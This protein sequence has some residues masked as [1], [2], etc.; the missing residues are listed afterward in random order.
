MRRFWIVLD[1]GKLSEYVNWKDKLDLH[2]DPID[3]RMAS[4]RESR[5]SERRFCFEVITPTYTRVYQAPSEEDMKA[6]I[7][8]INNA[9]QSA[10]ETRDVAT[11]YSAETSSSTSGPK[12]DIAAVLTGKSSSFSG[13][14]LTSYSSSHSASQKAVARHATTGDKPTYL[15]P[16]AADSGTSE[17]LQ[18]VR[19][20]DQGNRFCAD[21]NSESKVEWVSI[22]LGIVLCIECSGIHRSLGT[23]I[24]KVR[25]LTLDNSAFT[26]DIIDVLLLVGNRIS[27]M[28][29]EARLDRNTK[30]SPNSN[31]EQRL[32]FIQA[33]YDQRAFVAPTAQHAD[34]LLL[35]SIKRNDIQ[36]VLHALALRANPNVLDRSR[37]T[38]AVFLALAAADPAMPGGNPVSATFPNTRSSTTLGL[39]PHTLATIPQSPA[40]PMRISGELSRPGTPSSPDRRRFPVAE[41][42][43]QNGADLPPLPAPIP[44]TAAAMQY[45][46]FK[47]EQRTGARTYAASPSNVNTNLNTGMS[48][49]AG[50]RVSFGG[51]VNV[52]T[53]DASGDGYK[54]QPQSATTAKSSWAS[55]SG[56]VGGVKALGGGHDGLKR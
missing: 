33:K 10:F 32:Q 13:H 7:N 4:V 36:G 24:S 8:A 40:T 12:K 38:H 25:S 45:L 31:R 15:R 30:L 2:M 39:T 47:S 51:G 49:G 1:Q 55:A 6:W 42:L 34:D 50:N 53:F 23:H 20:V 44:L 17:V 19:E 22:N 21:C 27:N 43:L 37:A 14:R 52:G 18:K 26:P 16:E 28:T 56:F 54:G 3:L 11:G 48:Q 41:V 46:E 9:L 35:M 5:S 29:W